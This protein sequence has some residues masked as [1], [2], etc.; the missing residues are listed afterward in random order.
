MPGH[1]AAQKNGAYLY[2]GGYDQ[3]KDDIEQLVGDIRLDPDKYD[4]KADPKVHLVGYSLGGAAALGAAAGLGQKIDSLSVLFSSWNLASIRPE[5]IDRVFRDRLKFEF[6]AQEW[7]N[8]VK[9]LEKCRTTF[10]P[11]FRDLVWGDVDSKWFENGCKRMLFVHGLDDE[12]F[13]KEV[14]TKGILELYEKFL[15]LDDPA[16]KKR[17]CVFISVGGLD[18]MHAKAYVKDY[19]VAEYVANF[20]ANPAR[21]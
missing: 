7:G 17:E 4:L 20:I 13:P 9:D 5:A 8:T 6:G 10:D 14:T 11:V 12:L 16:H 1:R 2:Y 18:H 21:G 15:Q 19:P 3:V